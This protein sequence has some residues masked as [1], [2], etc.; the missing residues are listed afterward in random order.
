MIDKI[1]FI[2]PPIEVREKGVQSCRKIWSMSD[3]L[4]VVVPFN[5]AKLSPGLTM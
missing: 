2:R 3:G 4:T 1:G 5:E